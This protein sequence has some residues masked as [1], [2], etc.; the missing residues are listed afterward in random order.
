MGTR[1][2]REILERLRIRPAQS[3]TANELLRVDN[4]RKRYLVLH[5]GTR[6]WY[7][8]SYGTI[9]NFSGFLVFLTLLLL[10]ALHCTLSSSSHG[11][12]DLRGVSDSL[13]ANLIF[14][15]LFH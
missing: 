7:A 14:P 9:D 4:D 12:I 2:R 8:L 15:R 5:R 13:T 3:S 10:F 11:Q 1:F 6:G